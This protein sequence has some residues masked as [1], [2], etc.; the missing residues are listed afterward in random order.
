MRRVHRADLYQQAQLVPVVPAFDD[1]A[2]DDSLD[3]SA[4]DRYFFP[5]GCESQKFALVGHGSS[6][7]GHDC[8]SL[9]NDL[10]DSDFE[11]GKRR[12]QTYGKCPELLEADVGVVL[13]LS[14]TDGV[15]RRHLVNRF[16]PAFVPDF[17]KPA[18]NQRAILLRHTVPPRKSYPLWP[19]TVRSAWRC[20]N[21]CTR[22]SPRCKAAM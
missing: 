12:A 3:R 20:C 8:V 2:V 10:V 14:M 16:H 1:L 11:I 9:L 17:L 6:P 19:F 15:G 7:A 13:S 21:A 5:G 22:S 18:A 4:G